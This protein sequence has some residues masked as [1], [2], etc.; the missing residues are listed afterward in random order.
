[1]DILWISVWFSTKFTEQRLFGWMDIL[2]QLMEKGS[3][4]IFFLSIGCMQV[5]VRCRVNYWEFWFSA[6]L[7][8]LKWPS[9]PHL[10]S[11]SDCLIHCFSGICFQWDFR[12]SPWFSIHYNS[13]E[14]LSKKNSSVIFPGISMH[15]VRCYL[16]LGSFNEIMGHV[17]V[18]L[19]SEMF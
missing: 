14:F 18:W 13:I 19:R 7:I 15:K 9:Y 2:N 3:E 10:P 4:V 11:P 8:W 16:K 5:Y 12:S 6:F 17:L 1:M